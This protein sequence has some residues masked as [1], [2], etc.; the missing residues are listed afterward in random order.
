[1]CFDVAFAN[2][3]YPNAFSPNG[4]GVND[5]FKATQGRFVEF[6]MVIYNRWGV[7]IFSTTDPEI[8][9]DGTTNGQEAS[10]GAYVYQVNYTD[11]NNRSY[12]RT[13]TLVLIR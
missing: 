8:G 2:A 4:D 6:S 12:Q 9:W 7:I 13:G 10:P 3:Q 5:T 11:A 1:M